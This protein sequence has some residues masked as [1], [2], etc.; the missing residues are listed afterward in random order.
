MYFP[1]SRIELLTIIFVLKYSKLHHV[2][3]MTAGETFSFFSFFFFHARVKSAS[4]ESSQTP[5]EGKPNAKHSI[6]HD[7]DDNFLTQDYSGPDF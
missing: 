2:S 1:C 3:R 4:T 7:D 6:R 5:T